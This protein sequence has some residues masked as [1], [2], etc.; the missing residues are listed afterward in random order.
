M[1]PW[2]RSSV[3]VIPPTACL[4]V[5]KLIVS[6]F[7]QIGCASPVPQ[8]SCPGRKKPP[9]PPKSPP[10]PAEN[11]PGEEKE[12]PD[13]KKPPRDGKKLPRDDKKPART[14]KSPPREKNA[15]PEREM[16][17]L[18]TGIHIPERG[19]SYYPFR[20]KSPTRFQRLTECPPAISSGG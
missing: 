18:G 13:R 19:E 6:C 12:P 14:A 20:N 4:S 10:A 5:G 16:H 9:V 11:A 15:P 1:R 7:S 17:G 3:D 2:R 8:K